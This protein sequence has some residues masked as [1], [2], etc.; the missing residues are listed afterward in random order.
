M[1]QEDVCP[2]AADIADQAAETQTSSFDDFNLLEAIQKGV[3]AA[4]FKIPTPVQRDAIPLV[5]AGRDV[6]A[7][8]QTGTGKTAAF[9]L[10]AIHKMTFDR[11]IELLVITPTRELATQVCGEIHR[12]GRFADVKTGTVYGG[13][14]YGVQMRMLER[15][16][17]A[18]VATP[19]RL[20][21]LLRSGKLAGM[22]PWMVVLDEADEMLDMGFIDDVKEILSHVEGEH[23]TL[24]FSATIPD[25]IKRLSAKFMKD[26]AWVLT[27]EDRAATK[28]DIR[29]IYHVISEGERQ[30]AMIRL[31]E[32]LRPRKSIIFCR[33]RDESD[34]LQE[35]LSSLGFGAR[36]LHGD[37]EQR[38]RNTVMNGFRQGAYDILVATDI[39]S[40]G[41]DVPDVS[42]VF[43]Y[44]LPFDAKSYVHRI[45]RTGRAGKKGTAITLVTP[46]E[47]QTVQRLEQ[48]IGT[49]LEGQTVPSLKQLRVD[50]RLRL[51][52]KLEGQAISD[53]GRALVMELVTNGVDPIDLAAKLASRIFDQHTESGPE[54]IGLGQDQLDKLRQ[55]GRG[56]GRRDRRDGGGYQPHFQRGG[57]RN[58]ERRSFSRP[59]GKRPPKPA[60]NKGRP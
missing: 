46:K 20:L 14:S 12:L 57:R 18:L 5:M 28:E 49:K 32:S 23:Q 30:T 41:L 25:P 17:H 1:E 13:Q 59:A 22:R 19:G 10:P 6:I 36:A 52:E 11:G 31:L 56:G 37:M 60:A 34:R 33:T 40:R 24:L 48:G 3:E 38:Q 54:T 15:G 50:R 45:G 16:I 9:A 55:Q 44:N 58:D 51:M 8:A 42:H 27:A 53:N 43:N 26:P 29:Q 4:G 47:F 2:S 21:D 35:S 7:Q 39:A